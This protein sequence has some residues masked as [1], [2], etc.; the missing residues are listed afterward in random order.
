MGFRTLEINK[1]CEIHIKEGQL[2]VTSED[3]FIN[4]NTE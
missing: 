3:G 4:F 2:Q 1:A